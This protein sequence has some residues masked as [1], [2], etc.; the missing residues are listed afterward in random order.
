LQRLA[1][2]PPVVAL[3]VQ[4][5]DLVEGKAGRFLHERIHL[6]ERNAQFRGQ[7]RPDGALPGAAKAGEGDDRAARARG[8]EQRVHAGVERVG[9]VDQPDEG[10]V[11]VAGFDA[12]KKPE[13]KP[14][15]RSQFGPAEPA[16]LAQ[17]ANARR[18]ELQGLMGRAIIGR[19]V[20][21]IVHRTNPCDRERS[22]V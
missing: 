8:A 20:C 7:Q 21:T 13:G 3:S 5:E 19:H 17:A 22:A 11:P 18:Q 4:L 6:D 16:R 12:G 15:A 1:L 10:D 2:Q 9:Q 14:G